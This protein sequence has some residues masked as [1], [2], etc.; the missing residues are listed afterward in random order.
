MEPN[1]IAAFKLIEAAQQAMKQGE[2][3]TARQLAAQAA[4]SAPELEEV[5]LIMAALAS[6]RGSVAFL[7]KALGI[8]PQSE[9]A[10]KGLLWAQKRLQQELEKQAVTTRQAAA[11]ALTVAPVVEE[12]AAGEPEPVETVSEKEE[13]VAEKLEPVAVA[14]E[15][16]KPVAVAAAAVLEPKTSPRKPVTATQ[17]VQSEK[18]VARRNYSNLTIPL[19]VIACLALVAVLFLLLRNATSAAALING[20][21]FNGREHGPAW[22]EVNVAK[23]TQLA[24]ALEVVVLPTPSPLPVTLPD[25]P[26]LPTALDAPLPTEPVQP[27][28]TPLP[29]E[30]LPTR[31]KTPLPT[32]TSVPTATAQMVFAEGPSPTPLPTDTA[33]PIPTRYTAPTAK[34]NSGGGTI[35][36]LSGERWIDVDLTHQMVYAFEGNTV[37]NSF[38]VSTGTWQHPT[39]TGQYHVYVKYRSTTMSGPGYSLPNVPYTMYF[40][41]GYGIHGTYWHSNFGTPM[42]HGCV[43]LSIPDAEWMYNWA[44]VGTLVNVHY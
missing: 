17:T 37:I 21:V 1:Q 20:S 12:R 28:N 41:K 7:Q 34:P 22:A 24:E 23:P 25:L 10:Q 36:G 40:Y 5:W 43:N 44:S 8:N 39:V 6:P 38:L 14:P 32:E 33:V 26:L 4:Q 9:R 29:T 16:E 3:I 19:V 27:P 31:T 30:I 15:A 42:S 13:Q 18:K 11:E 35:A 2:Y